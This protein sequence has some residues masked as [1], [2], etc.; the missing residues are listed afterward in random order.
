MSVERVIH[1]SSEGEFFTCICVCIYEL[2]T[3]YCAFVSLGSEFLCTIKLAPSNL[4]ALLCCSIVLDIGCLM[5]SMTIHMK[6]PRKNCSLTAG[7]SNVWLYI[8]L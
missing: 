4:T 1:E 7:V 8:P 6:Q 2:L 3:V 5:A